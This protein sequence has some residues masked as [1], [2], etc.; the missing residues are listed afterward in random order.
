MKSWKGKGR[1]VGEGVE[2]MDGSLKGREGKVRGG[3]MEEWKGRREWRN[4]KDGERDERK[5]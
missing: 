4:R 3:E 5:G 1:W 2:R